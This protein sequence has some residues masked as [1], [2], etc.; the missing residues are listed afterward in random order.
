MGI[1]GSHALDF[2]KLKVLIFVPIGNSH[3][4]GAGCLRKEAKSK[5][6]KE[7]FF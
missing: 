2:A 5:N 4:G 6:A 3:S 7:Y 1:S